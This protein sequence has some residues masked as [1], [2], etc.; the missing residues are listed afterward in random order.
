MEYGESVYR[1]DI[2]CHTCQDLYNSTPRCPDCQ[3]PETE[4]DLRGIPFNSYNPGDVIFG[5]MKELGWVVVKGLR[6]DD[7]TYTKINDIAR[8]GRGH[9]GT[10][11]SIEDRGNNRQMKYKHTSKNGQSD[12]EKQPMLKQFLSGIKEKVFG[13]YM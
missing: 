5:D 2:H 9:D 8:K 1:N 10:W 6:I 7:G 11:H 13:S 12:W 3:K 4:I